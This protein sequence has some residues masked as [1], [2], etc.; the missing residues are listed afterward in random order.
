VWRFALWQQLLFALG[1]SRSLPYVEN[2]LFSGA[3]DVS[4]F[5][6]SFRAFF[7]AL[8][9]FFAVFRTTFVFLDIRSG[10]PR[11]RSEQRRFWAS[12]SQVNIRDVTSNN[13]ILTHRSI[14]PVSR[15]LWL[16]MTLVPPHLRAPQRGR[17]G[18]HRK[19]VE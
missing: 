18:P 7:A 1:L 3:L 4:T 16:D 5:S 13:M 11:W 15:H 6:S 14:A 17:A 9:A 2:G 19:S 8:F 12:V 10:P